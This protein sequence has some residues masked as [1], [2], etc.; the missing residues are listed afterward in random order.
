MDNVSYWDI[1]TSAQVS[2][3]LVLIAVSLSVIAFRLFDTFRK[4]L[5]VAKSDVHWP[6]KFCAAII[7]HAQTA[8]DFY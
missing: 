4:D 3:A 1:M 6:V 8:F 2:T 7:P 5:K